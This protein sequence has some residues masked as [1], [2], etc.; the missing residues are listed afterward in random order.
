MKGRINWALIKSQDQAT[1]ERLA[2]EERRAFG[3]KLGGAKWR[4]VLNPRA[5]NVKSIRRRLGLSQSA[6]AKRFCLSQRTVQQWEQGRSKPD[7]PARNLLRVIEFAP[8]T[9][10]RA[11]DGAGTRRK[12]PK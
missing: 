2:D 6:F 5:P 9:V 12:R 4:R 11:V 7:Q 1:I 8:Q 3:I 10:A